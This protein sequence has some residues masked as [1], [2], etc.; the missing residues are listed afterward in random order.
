MKKII[1]FC[2]NCPFLEEGDNCKLYEFLNNKKY[3]IDEP[4]KLSIQNNCPLK[5]DITFTFKIFS[6][7]R[8]EQI[9]KSEENNDI[10]QLKKLYNN[11][12]NNSSYEDEINEN[13]DKIKRELLSLSEIGKDLNNTLNNFNK[14]I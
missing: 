3:H 1:N 13:I 11:E 6:K 5:N 10:D 2:L 12:E 9:T 14:K 4:Y 7:E 8:L